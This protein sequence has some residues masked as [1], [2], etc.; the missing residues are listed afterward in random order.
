MYLSK[1]IDGVQ[2]V[3]RKDTSKGIAA[4]ARRNYDILGFSSYTYVRLSL[5]R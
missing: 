1:V 2:R 5:L 4:I 3:S